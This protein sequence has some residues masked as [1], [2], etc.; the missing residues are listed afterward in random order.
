[1]P[2]ADLVQPHELGQGVVGAHQVAINERQGHELHLVIVFLLLR[3]QLDIAAG[4]NLVRQV[5][6][7]I[8]GH[9]EGEAVE[10]FLQ[11]IQPAVADDLLECV[12]GQLALDKDRVPGLEGIEAGAVQAVWP[13][14]FALAVQIQRGLGDGGTSGNPPVPRFAG[15]LDDALGALGVGGL[16][17]GRFI[18]GHEG[19]GDTQERAGVGHTFFGA[20]RLDV[21]DHDAQLVEGVDHLLHLQL[22]RLAGRG[23]PACH[24]VADVIRHVL[25]QLGLIPISV[26][27]LWCHNEHCIDLALVVEH[28]RVVDE[29]EAFARAH[30]C[31][32][33]RLRMLPKALQI[34]RLMHKRL[35][36]ERIPLQKIIHDFLPFFEKGY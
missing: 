17:G 31:E 24:L 25:G 19:R 26:Y 27:A 35:V 14:E 1:M 16:D 22:L 11:L 2:T 21:H 34:R 30:L 13:Q 15:H 10:L 28:G 29:H 5:Q 3:G 18:H 32:Q 36:L 7:L 33:R 23:R 6:A 8:L 9:A 12:G 4:V 20:E